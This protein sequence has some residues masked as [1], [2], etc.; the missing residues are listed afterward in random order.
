MK[1]LSCLVVLIAC[2]G[3][4]KQTTAARGGEGTSCSQQIVLTCPAGHK[5]ACDD[6]LAQVTQ[7]DDAPATPGASGTAIER[8]HRCVLK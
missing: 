3:G 6:P 5:D 4:N 7:P 8:T 1:I 2:G